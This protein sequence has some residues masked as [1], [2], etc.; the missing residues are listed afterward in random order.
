MRNAIT[1]LV[2]ALALMFGPSATVAQQ[3]GGSITVTSQYLTQDGD[4]YG[5]IFGLSS[6]V[7]GPVCV[8]PEVT[9][10]TN[11]TGGVGS[12]YELQSGENIRIGQFNRADN[13][14]AWSVN[15]V[16]H[17]HRGTC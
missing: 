9:E 4:T 12:V 15:V 11:V 3:D 8:V 7:D 14:Q 2:L 5:V 10:A 13:S 16:A 6:S 1:T 17:G